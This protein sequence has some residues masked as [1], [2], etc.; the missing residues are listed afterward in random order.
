[1]VVKR[2][3]ESA[4]VEAA[5]GK[6]TVD[7]APRFPL[8]VI[9]AL[10]LMVSLPGT[11]LLLKGA[12][13]RLVQIYGVLRMDDMQRIKL[14]DV[15]GV[16]SDREVEKGLRRGDQGRRLGSYEFSSEKER[17]WWTRHGCRK[18][19]SSGALR[20]R[21]RIGTSSSLV[22]R[23]TAWGSLRSTHQPETTQAWVSGC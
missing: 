22:P 11:A 3:L 18:V 8:G 4:V 7:K 6:E 1:M 15:D 2:Y 5:A 9:A 17:A 20:L 14:A 13:A 21:T 10:E 16:G 19:M 23:P 12:W